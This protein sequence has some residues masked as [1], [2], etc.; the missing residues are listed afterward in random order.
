MY[1]RFLVLLNDNTLC[2]TKSF[3]FLC[4]DIVEE[5]LKHERTFNNGKTWVEVTY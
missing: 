5:V 1:D 3:N 2:Y 4:T